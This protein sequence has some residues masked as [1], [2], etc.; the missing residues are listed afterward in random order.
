MTTPDLRAKDLATLRA[1]F[2]RFPSVRQVRVFGS[3]AT[4]HAQ[5][6]SDIDLAID[7]PDAAQHEW[8]A[9][10]EALEEAPIIYRIDVVRP[11]QVAGTA[12]LAA[13]ERDGITI[14]PATPANVPG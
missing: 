3:R 1:I 7:A 9:L 6:A 11:E 13:I 5:R 4:G 8:N 14:H 10:V 12:L 2:D